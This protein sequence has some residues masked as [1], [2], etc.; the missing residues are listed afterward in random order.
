MTAGDQAN[1]RHSHPGRPPQTTI[2]I[3]E[4]ELCHHE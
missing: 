3:G 1:S 4:D 2:D